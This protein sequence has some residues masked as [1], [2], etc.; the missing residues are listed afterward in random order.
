MTRRILKSSAYPVPLSSTEEAERHLDHLRQLREIR[1]GKIK[2]DRQRREAAQTEAPTN[3]RP[4]LLKEFLDLYQARTKPQQ[5]GL[6]FEGLLR[7]IAELEKLEVTG[8]FRCLG[9]QIDGG[10]KY[11]GEN[12]MIE[13]K[14]HDK[15]A[16]TEPL[17]AFAGKVEGKMYGRGVFV[18]VNGFM[19]D[20]V[21]GLMR[22]KALKTVLVDGEDLVLV[23]E[24]HINFAQM[25]DEKV[26]AAQL[27][28]E[29]YVHPITKTVKLKPS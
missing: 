9:E 10:L 6:Q 24:G 16:S 22:G 13:A 4:A 3:L 29:I 21:Q 23:L 25:L 17:Y 28:G 8:P 7:K 12:Y 14:W 26:R 2:A 27:R 1:D 18:S 20:P 19:P 5:R 15:S 11:D